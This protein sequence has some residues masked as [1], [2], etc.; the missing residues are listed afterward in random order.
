MEK[1]S[2]NNNDQAQ[3][4]DQDDGMNDEKSN[5]SHC[6]VTWNVHI[7]WS[8]ESGRAKACARRAA[9]ILRESFPQVN[10]HRVTSL[11]QNDTFRGLIGIQKTNQVVGADDT[12][13]Q[14]VESKQSSHH[15]TLFICFIS[16]TG[17]GEQCE[18]IRQVWKSL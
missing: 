14:I 16:T 8:T 4:Q 13:P 18:A 10:I 7:V 12:S 5:L 1:S 6:Q 17:D 15:K 11:E 3:D 2:S 9:R